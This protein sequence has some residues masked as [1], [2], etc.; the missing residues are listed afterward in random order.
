M[1]SAAS[2]DAFT[3]PAWN[4]LHSTHRDL[5]LSLG[6]ACKYPAR[7]APFS[8]IEENTE[9]AMTDLFRL[10][11]PGEVTFVINA[12]PP[13]IEGLTVELGP[14]C[15]RMD[16]PAD[17]QIPAAPKGM[18]IAALTCADAPAMV[19]LTDVA[20]P[21]Y[22]RPET[23]RMGS[24]FGIWS[25]GKLVAMAGERMCPFPF[26]EISAVCTHPEHRGHGYAAALVTRVLQ[27]Q[28]E[29]GAF[30]TLWVLT[31]NLKA[32]ELYRWLGFLAVSEVQLWRITRQIDEIVPR[33]TI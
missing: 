32:I 6:L 19:G 20:F 18:R 12:Q 21:G 22:F 33:G 23:C 30:S 14:L 1:P 2:H 8:A 13:S 26:R 17:A 15:L 29:K 4:A 9:Q 27:S 7:I 16:F 10:M 25:E 11:D 5:A 31:S 24:Y 3:K 28:A